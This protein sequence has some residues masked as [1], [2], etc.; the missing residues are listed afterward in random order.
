M[1]TTD[2]RIAEL[3]GWRPGGDGRHFFHAPQ[4][5]G[6]ATVEYAN[7]T[8]DLNLTAR[9]IER[10]GWAWSTGRMGKTCKAA[11]TRPSPLQPMPDV[12]K[13]ATPAEALALAFLAA[14]EAQKKEG[15]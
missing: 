7:F 4:A 13:A 5:G 9:E 12:V 15:E 6:V 2:T 1:S 11:V 14:L 8:T 3:L 10:R